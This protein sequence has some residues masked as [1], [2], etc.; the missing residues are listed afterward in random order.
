MGYMKCCWTVQNCDYH[1]KMN[2]S[3]KYWKFFLK[4]LKVLKLKDILFKRCT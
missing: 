1:M 4:A 2:K 3:T